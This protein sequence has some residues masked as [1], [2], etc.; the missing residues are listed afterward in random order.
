MEL[1]SHI[2]DDRP[3]GVNAEVHPSFAPPDDAEL[4]W[5]YFDMEKYVAMLGMEALWLSRA[6][7]LGDPFE[8]SLTEA[9]VRARPDLYEDIPPEAMRRIERHRMLMTRHT[10]ISCWHRNSVESAAMWRLYAD[11]A[12]IAIISSYR[13]IRD[14]VGE[15][16]HPSSDTKSIYAGNVEYVSY[17]D[18][19]IP[20]GNLFDAFM[21]K[22]HSYEHE[23]E[24][25]LVTMD[26]PIR[27]DPAAEDGRSADLE[28]P[29]PG[30]VRVPV[31]LDQLIEEVRISPSA[32]PW[33]HE[34]VVAVTQRFGLEVSVRQSDLAGDPVY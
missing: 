9:N 6:D 22:R 5:R 30:G 16:S 1:L 27:T 4:L 31:K 23:R 11:R 17:K 13:R 21:H 19:F 20:E 10:Y 18:F 25:R 15:I 26:I 24:V 7:T 28:A 8:G 14:A 32:P 33:L 12:G 3:F 34:A 29:S 2:D